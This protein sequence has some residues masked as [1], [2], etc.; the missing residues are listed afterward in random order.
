MTTLFVLYPWSGKDLRRF[1]TALLKKW[2][3]LEITRLNYM[4][5]Y[6]LDEHKKIIKQQQKWVLIQ[7]QNIE[8]ATKLIQAL[9][10]HSKDVVIQTVPLS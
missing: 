6:S 5:S 10:P 3:A 7:T 1:I 8:W 4:Q 9:H 2:V